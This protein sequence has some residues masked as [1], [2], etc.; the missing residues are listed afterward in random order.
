MDNFFLKV[1]IRWGVCEGFYGLDSGSSGSSEFAKQKK[2]E[3]FAKIVA[4]LLNAHCKISLQNI[5]YL[6]KNEI[7]GIKEQDLFISTIRRHLSW[8]VKYACLFS[9]EFRNRAKILLLILNRNLDFS[10]QWKDVK[11]ILLKH[12]CNSEKETTT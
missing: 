2:I 6:V 1:Y 8:N 3:P 9:R 4:T 5:T 11:H 12:L 10:N 7:R